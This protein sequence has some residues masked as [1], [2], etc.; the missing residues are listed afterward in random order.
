VS[1]RTA[2]ATQRNPASENKTKQNKTKHKKKPPP[3]TKQ[4]VI[5]LIGLYSDF[6]PWVS[7]RFWLSQMEVSD[8]FVDEGAREGATGRWNCV[9]TPIHLL[10]SQV[11]IPAE[12]MPACKGDWAPG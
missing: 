1:S 4:L 3:T 2:R 10:I 11:I 5:G 6:L 8:R 12:Q 7:P 9:D